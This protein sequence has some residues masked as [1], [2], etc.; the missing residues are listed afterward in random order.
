MKKIFSVLLILCYSFAFAQETTISGKVENIGKGDTLILVYDPLLLGVNPLIQKLVL[1][2][3]NQFQCKLNVQSQAIVELKFKEQSILLFVAKGNHI[4][5]AFDA[6]DFEKS[7]KIK[8]ENALENDFLVKFYQTFKVDFTSSLMLKKVNSMSIDVLEM[9]LFEAK[10]AQ[11]DYYKSFPE[12]SKFS[13]VFKKYIENQIRWN[14]WSYI[15]AYPIIRGNANQAQTQVI[16]LP[17]SVLE[18]LDEKKIQDESALLSSSYRN[19][20]IHYITYFNSKAHG[21]VK[22]ADVNKAMEDKHLFAREHLPT[23]VYQYYLAYL[24]DSQCQFCLPS[25]VRNTFSALSATPNSEAYTNLVKAKCGEIMSKNDEAIKAKEEDGKWFKAITPDGKELSLASLKGKVVYL[26]FW[27]SW[28]GPCRKEFPFSKLL[29]EKLSDKQRKEVVFLYISID[30]EEENWR[31]GMKDLQIENQRNVHSKGG[32]ESGAA[33]FFKLE[34]IP[35]YML[36][37]KKGN[38]VDSDAKRPSDPKIL[39]DI[40]KLIGE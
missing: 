6:K 32:W 17:N 33:K 13:E 2:S 22:Y 5:L 20:L 34:S 25:V 24:L 10:K 27:A 8:G 9:D 37:D 31:K 35:R 30:E 23:K 38:I 12:Q 19:F 3:E 4:S 28:C 1:N 40:L 16:S 26:D 21:F 11:S 14:Y 15:L 29:Q 7:L 39:S 18:T 36:M